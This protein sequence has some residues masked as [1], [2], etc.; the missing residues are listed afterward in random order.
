[1]K[2]SPSWEANRFSDS[3]EFPCILWNPKVYYLIQKCLPTVSTLSQIS[4]V[5]ATILL[6]KI[7]TILSSHLRLGLLS[8]IFP[9]GFPTKTLYTLLLSLPYVLRAR[10]TRSSRFDNEYY[11]VSATDN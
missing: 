11:L 7:C 10:P 5:H 3:Q 6:L 9:S 4:P 1:M 2:Q 8:G